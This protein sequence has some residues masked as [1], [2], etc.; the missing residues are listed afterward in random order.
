MKESKLIKLLK[1]LN[2]E[3]FKR[4]GWFV[5][6]DYFNTDG[7]LISL[8][9]Y[10]KR[11]FPDFT[12][13]NLTKQ[14]IFQHVFPGTHFNDAKLRN[15]LSK[16]SLL[17]E[18]YLVNLEWENDPILKSEILIKA[19]EKRNI[20]QHEYTK[21]NQQLEHILENKKMKSIE[22]FNLLF[23][24]HSNY[25]FNPNTKKAGEALESFKK[26][27][28]YL[29]EFYSIS[30]LKFKCE[31][32]ARKRLFNERTAEELV[33]QK[34]AEHTGHS[35]ALIYSHILE[36]Q[37]NSSIQNYETAKNIFKKYFDHIEEREQQEA[38]QLLL[39]HAINQHNRGN[40]GY[41]EEVLQLYQY[42]LKTSI[43]IIGSKISD[44]TFLN[45][46]SQG[47]TLGHFEWTRN[48]IE[49]YEKLLSSEIK[50]ETVLI[51][52]GYWHFF[53]SDFAKTIDAL[54]TSTFKH[55][56]YKIHSRW[57]L[58]RSFYELYA[59]DETYFQLVGSSIM[60]FKKFLKRNKKIMALFCAC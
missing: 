19:F 53:K 43:L 15:L 30:K 2:K 1:A 20:D 32:N 51:S 44:A 23:F 29:D 48:F 31:L 18:K 50:K 17:L 16:M 9:E 49:E 42:G 37:E 25:Y 8:Y 34:R 28:L 55:H 6:S 14:H 5:K 41:A 3:E 38:F 60:A 54:Q 35:L 59:R 27:N 13:K 10:L 11:Y 12:S 22:D 40:K 36:L 45:I 47:S 4:L 46:T 33:Q 57:L 7:N 58:V 56:D 21:K 24:L 39:N 26:A 52:W